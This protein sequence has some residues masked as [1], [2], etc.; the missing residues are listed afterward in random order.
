LKVFYILSNEVQKPLPLA[1]NG[2]FRAFLGF[3][4][5][6]GF[7]TPCFLFFTSYQKN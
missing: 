2:V 1:S 3:S 7:C 4:G 5:F 6:F